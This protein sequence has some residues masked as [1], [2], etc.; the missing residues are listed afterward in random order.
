MNV[1]IA[2]AITTVSQ[3]L[4]DRGEPA[5]KLMS[6]SQADIDESIRSAVHGIVRIDT[7]SRDILIF[8][9]KAKSGDLAKAASE[10]SEQRL[11][12]VMLITPEAFKKTQQGAAVSLFGPRHEA[13]T[14][15]EL[16]L[17]I[18]RHILVPKH[19]IVPGDEVPDLKEMFMVSSLKQLPIIK[20]Y[21]AMA[22]YI[23]ARPGDL[24]KVTRMCPTAGTQIAYRF[25]CA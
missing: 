18:S 1:K 20:S 9:N 12:N 14:L 4:A 21:D 25:C 15:S 22:K 13:F 8:T 23:R 17:N 24:V 6:L 2:R 16:S 10:T 3:M 11:D 5:P 7:G 19:E